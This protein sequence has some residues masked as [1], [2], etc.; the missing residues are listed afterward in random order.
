MTYIPIPL[1]LVMLIEH[2]G[3]ADFVPDI[4]VR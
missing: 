2:I 3:S 4:K 1:A